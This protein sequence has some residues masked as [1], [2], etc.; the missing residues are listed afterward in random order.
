M[1]SVVTFKF[2]IQEKGV[3]TGDIRRVTLKAPTTLE[4]L[5]A[6]AKDILGWDDVVFHFRDED[7]DVVTIASQHE[8]DT[9][10][11][12]ANGGPVRLVVFRPGDVPASEVKPEPVKQ[13]PAPVPEP[14][15]EAVPA[16]APVEPVAEPVP[17]PVP[18]ADAAA[19]AAAAAAN[20]PGYMLALAP[21]ATIPENVMLQFSAIAEFFQRMAQ[22]MADFA[23]RIP[24]ILNE[25]I[26]KMSAGMQNNFAP[27]DAS[28]NAARNSPIPDGVQPEMLQSYNVVVHRLPESVVHPGVECANCHKKPIAGMRYRCVQCDADLCQDCVFLPGVHPADH[29][30]LPVCAPAVGSH[31]V[32]SAIQAGEQ[33]KARATP[34]VEQMKARA[35]PVVEQVKARTAPVVEQVKEAVAPVVEQ[36][37]TRAAPVVESVK[38]AVKE[39]VAPAPAPADASAPVDAPAPA[40][41][42][43]DAKQMEMLTQL[44]E[45]GFPDEQ[46]VPLIRQNKELSRIIERLVR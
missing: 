24:V 15:V 9:A 6:A 22:Q 25:G 28:V 8:L 4:T 43:L 2:L 27:L 40:E 39:A 37:K 45:M 3:N 35:A 44:R 20:P 32:N 17:E 10:I 41:P 18:A 7:G 11:S 16:P 14:A 36:V 34:V 19:L 23:P 29:R 33:V 1:S 30:F 26:R 5:H 38:E 21:D 31:I 46:T 13:A 42:L 12:I